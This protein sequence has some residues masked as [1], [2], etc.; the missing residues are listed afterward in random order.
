MYTSLHEKQNDKQIWSSESCKNI[1]MFPYA[2]KNT[3]LLYFKKR[4]KDPYQKQKGK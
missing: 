2:I 3:R 4:Y 1:N